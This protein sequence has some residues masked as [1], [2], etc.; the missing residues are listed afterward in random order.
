M[1]AVTG[2]YRYVLPF[3]PFP[4]EHSPWTVLFI[5][6]PTTNPVVFFTSILRLSAADVS[7]VMWCVH[8]VSIL[9]LG[10]R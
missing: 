6:A 3:T 8:S 4:L 9:L 2:Q 10:L 7:T 5:L 1:P